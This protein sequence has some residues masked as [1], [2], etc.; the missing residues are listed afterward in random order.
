MKQPNITI[1]SRPRGNVSRLEKLIC[2]TSV[3]TSVVSRPADVVV[4]G[5]VVVVATLKIIIRINCNKSKLKANL[6]IRALEKLDERHL[7]VR[8]M[9]KIGYL[10]HVGAKTFARRIEHVRCTRIVAAYRGLL[11]QKEVNSSHMNNGWENVPGSVTAARR[12]G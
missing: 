9:I 12:T 1:V 6:Q 11:W 2:P 10:D 5:G 4:A 7:P 8:S 3:G